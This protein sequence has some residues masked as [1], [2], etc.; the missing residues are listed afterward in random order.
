MQPSPQSSAKNYNAFFTPVSIM[1]NLATNANAQR[2]STR[3]TLITLKLSLLSANQ[4]HLLDT[5]EWILGRPINIA[6]LDSPLSVYNALSVGLVGIRFL[7]NMID[8]LQY[9]FDDTLNRPASIDGPA[10][11]RDSRFNEKIKQHRC[12]MV[13][14][15]VLGTVNALANYAAYFHIPPGVPN[16]LMLGFT[17]FDIACSY[18]KL[19]LERQDY[20]TES[21][22]NDTKRA[23]FFNDPLEFKRL[24][25]DLDELKLDLDKLKHDHEKNESVLLFDIAV[26]C[27][28]LGGFIA[29]FILSPPA[30]LPLC[31]LVC[32]IAIAMLLSDD[33]YGEWKKA[34]LINNNEQNEKNET[35]VQTAWNDLGLTMA[36]NTIRPF[37]FLGA[38][39]VSVPAAIALTLAYMAYEYGFLTGFP[40]LISTAC[41]FNA[42]L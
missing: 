20:E 11:T 7:V 39:T 17:V 26:T 15:A 10:S 32:N 35:N 29:A 34:T 36:K 22:D 24:K 40:D 2:L 31:Y 38:F 27:L 5:I 41:N 8:I 16:F 18:Y 21:R 3:F 25:L 28:M 23:M 33:K 6:I 9:G 14:D 1:R 19:H 37:I 4:H 30:L 13:N 12:V 42:S